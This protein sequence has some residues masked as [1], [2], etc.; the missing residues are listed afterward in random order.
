MEEYSD[1][2]YWVASSRF[3]LQDADVERIPGQPYAAKLKPLVEEIIAVSGILHLAI[4]LKEYREL[5]LSGMYRSIVWETPEAAI[6]LDE[7]KALVVLSRLEAWTLTGS[8]DCLVF[9]GRGSVQNLTLESGTL[10]MLGPGRL[11]RGALSVTNLS[12]KQIVSGSGA[13]L[14][15]PNSG[16][17]QIEELSPL[18][19]IPPWVSVGRI[20]SQDEHLT[21]TRQ[22][23]DRLKVQ[24]D[25]SRYVHD[26]ERGVRFGILGIGRSRLN[27]AG[28]AR[29]RAQDIH[30]FANS[31][32]ALIKPA[33]SRKLRVWRR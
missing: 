24:P 11:G 4:Q 17:A 16:G 15:C 29:S 32:D 3:I 33:S 10:G 5:N 26:T 30:D 13:K 22:C 6:R 9:A 14:K 12:V 1:T 8:G 19:S 31:S 7:T 23:I 21:R 20:M 27:E 2:N 28:A 18:I 25:L